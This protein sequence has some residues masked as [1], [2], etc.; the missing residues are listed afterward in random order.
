MSNIQVKRT[1]R[2]RIWHLG[3]A[4]AA[5]AL[6]MSVDPERLPM[7]SKLWLFVLASL[8]A[9]ISSYSRV[10]FLRVATWTTGVYGILPPIGVIITWIAASTKLGRVPQA[11]L[12]DP[13]TIG[14]AV[15]VARTL[16]FLTLSLTATMGLLCL[17]LVASNLIASL[18]K[19]KPY[20]AENLMLCTFPVISWSA[21]VL[22]FKCDPGG[23]ITWFFD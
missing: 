20:T 17:L 13:G 6:I 23:V 2:L 22:F 14:P 15:E 9:A 1:G 7:A 8:A 5:V 16:T 12:D 10:P 11:N 18:L 21:C 4:V 3:I 19:K